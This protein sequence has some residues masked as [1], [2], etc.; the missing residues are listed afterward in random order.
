MSWAWLGKA[1]NQN[2]QIKRQQA[3]SG[4]ILEPYPRLPM[5][6]RPIMK[7]ITVSNLFPTAGT[8]GR[9][10]GG[11]HFVNGKCKWGISN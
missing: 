5:Y 10:L 4:S 11:A 8:S 1:V 2:I 7:I 9:S 6:N 3:I